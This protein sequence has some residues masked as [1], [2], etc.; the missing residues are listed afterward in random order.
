MFSAFMNVPSLFPELR[1][2]SEHCLILI[3]YLLAI[4]MFGGWVDASQ[5]NKARRVSVVFGADRVLEFC[6]ANDIDVIVRAHQCGTRLRAWSEG[7]FG[8]NIDLFCD[9]LLAD[10][11]EYSP[12]IFFSHSFST[13]T[14]SHALSSI[15]SDGRLRVFRT[16]SFDY[17]FL[18]YAGT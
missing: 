6:A 8:N 10:F 17:N 14:P 16:R 18:R 7:L 5:E 3:F 11:F 12:C 4:V 2:F 15:D 9:G 13:S 1:F